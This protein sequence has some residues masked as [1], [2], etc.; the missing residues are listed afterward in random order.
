ML[1]NFLKNVKNHFLQF[2]IFSV[3]SYHAAHLKCMILRSKVHCISFHVY[4][5]IFVVALLLVHV[6][7]E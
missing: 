7:F 6:Y 5:F 2:A 1:S 4:F 3:I